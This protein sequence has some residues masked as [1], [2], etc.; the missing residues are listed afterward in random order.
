MNNKVFAHLIKMLTDKRREIKIN[1]CP[2][3]ADPDAIGSKPDGMTIETIDALISVSEHDVDGFV[4]KKTERTLNILREWIKE[5][6][7]K[8]PLIELKI[9]RRRNPIEIIEKK[10]LAKHLAIEEAKKNRYEEELKRIR[11]PF[12][13]Y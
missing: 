2:A 1:A 4:R 10:S 7:D 13:L 9:R 5:W 8:P 3:L 6:A 11:R 12:T